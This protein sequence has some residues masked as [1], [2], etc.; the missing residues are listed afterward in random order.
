MFTRRQCR[1][2]SRDR[3]KVEGLILVTTHAASR[4]LDVT[5][6]ADIRLFAPI[7]IPHKADLVYRA[8][9]LVDIP[10]TFP[11]C[12][13]THD[14]SLRGVNHGRDSVPLVA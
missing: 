4:R 12:T 2:G 8:L 11:R 9:R 3:P 13:A 7:Y 6:L 1:L 10:F 5:C 14:P